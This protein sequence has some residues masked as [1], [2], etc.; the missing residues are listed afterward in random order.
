MKGAPGLTRNAND[1]QHD[2]PMQTNENTFVVNVTR[3]CH[4]VT[5]MRLNLSNLLA[6]NEVKFL[7]IS[8][9]IR[10]TNHANCII[11]ATK[12]PAKCNTFEQPNIK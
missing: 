5:E 1:P 6:H 7:Y 9:D 8:K 2:P 3:Q 4:F 11:C 10:V 12:I